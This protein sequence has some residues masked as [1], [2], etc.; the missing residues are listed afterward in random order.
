MLPMQKNM[1]IFAAKMNNATGKEFPASRKSAKAFL[2]RMP[3]KV[4]SM[5]YNF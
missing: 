2:R 3:K 5:N 4:F 1:H